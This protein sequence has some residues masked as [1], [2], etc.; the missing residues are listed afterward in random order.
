MRTLAA[1]AALA[2]LLTGCGGT[3]A[4]PEQ[5]KQVSDHLTGIDS[6]LGI[7]VDDEQAECLAE[8]YLGSDLS[9]ELKNDIRDGKPPV[10]TTDHDRDVLA[11]LADDIAENCL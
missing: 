8:L 1:T 11:K 4:D 10:A 5:V 9:D 7:T 6:P 2:L 3:T